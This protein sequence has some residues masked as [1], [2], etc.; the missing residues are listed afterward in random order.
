[1]RIEYEGVVEQQPTYSHVGY[2]S[3]AS[4]RMNSEPAAQAGLGIAALGLMLT[5]MAYGQRGRKARRTASIALGIVG[6]LMLLSGG[7]LAATRGGVSEKYYPSPYT[8]TSYRLNLFDRPLNAV[9]EAGGELP[10]ELPRR[11]VE[12]FQTADDVDDP[13]LDAWGRPFR[14]VRDVPEEFGRPYN[15][16]SA[17]A[18]GE[19]GTMD[20]IDLSVQRGMA[21]DRALRGEEPWPERRDPPVHWEV[22]LENAD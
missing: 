10:A 1:M 14:Y 8:E 3:V 21:H 17:G 20:D 6:M 13:N 16:I 7:I 15:V 12:D 11:E 2:V 18:D 4:T 9:V 22:A 19:F 5:L